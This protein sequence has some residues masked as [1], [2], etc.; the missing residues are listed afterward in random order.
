MTVQ[1]EIEDTGMGMAADQLPSLFIP[2]SQL[3]ASTA[4]RFGGTGLG[5]AI[6]KRLIEMMGG[7]IGVDSQPGKGSRFWFSLPFRV[8]PNRPNQTIG[9]IIVET[10]QFLRPLRILLAEDNRINQMLV[11]T[12]LQKMG[13]TVE[14]AD[15]G[16]FAVK[17][18]AAGEFDAVLMDM[19][20]PEMNGDEATRVI[21][22]M[23]PPKNQIPILAL[24]A[25]AMVEQRDRYLAAGVNDLVSKPI[26]W[27]VLSA[28]LA[29][30]TDLSER[31]SDG[32]SGGVT[33]RLLGD[34]HHGLPAL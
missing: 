14:V 25:D 6:T 18:V 26:D 7:V 21:R 24:T 16:R 1:V 10:L 30:H 29:R 2:F 33:D 11:R 17:A 34:V 13:H 32:L 3:G 15:N 28:A 19:Q 9:D 20:M 12:M 4:R 23:P 22:A 31:A 27:D 5:L 8:A